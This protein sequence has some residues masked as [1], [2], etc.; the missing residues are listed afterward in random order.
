MVWLVVFMVIC[1]FDVYGF[2]N[3]TD[4]AALILIPTII[5]LF[6]VW[7]TIYVYLTINPITKEITTDTSSEQFG[8]NRANT[9]AEMVL[10]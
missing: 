10:H 6:V 3:L 7:G 5:L 1:M 2:Q 4:V 8:S 9:F